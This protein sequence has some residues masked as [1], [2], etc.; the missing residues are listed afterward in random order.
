MLSLNTNRQQI[1]SLVVTGVTHSV[2]MSTYYDSNSDVSS[3]ELSPCAGEQ[4]QDLVLPPDF[5]DRF[6]ASCPSTLSLQQWGEAVYHAHTSTDFV[7]QWHDRFYDFLSNRTR[8][9]CGMLL[10]DAKIDDD[11]NIRPLETLD[12]IDLTSFEEV[13][14]PNLP[15]MA[16]SLKYRLEEDME[17]YEPLQKMQMIEWTH[18]TLSARG[19]THLP[20]RPL[21]GLT[22]LPEIVDERDA[23]EFF[24]TY[25]WHKILDMLNQELS[26]RDGLIAYSPMWSFFSRLQVLMNY[27]SMDHFA[28]IMDLNYQLPPS[29]LQNAFDSHPWSNEKRL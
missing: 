22:K 28:M 17:Y 27:P 26:R 25:D 20:P 19:A 3:L 24:M 10:H 4:N 7:N 11:E 21:K 23:M 16:F 12:F 6:R 18:I 8:E 1:S 29:T 2:K 9:Y 15:R 14:R 13:C 5:L